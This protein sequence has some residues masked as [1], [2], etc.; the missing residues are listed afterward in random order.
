MCDLGSTLRYSTLVV[1]KERAVSDVSLWMEWEADL[2][3][4]YRRACMYSE[5]NIFRSTTRIG[6][7]PCLPPPPLSLGY[8]YRYP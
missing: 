1:G 6:E 3:R 4:R 5:I 7:H 8:M 2:H